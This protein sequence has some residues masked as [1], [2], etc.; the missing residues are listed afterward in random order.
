MRCSRNAERPGHHAG[1]IAW[2]AAV[3]LLMPLARAPG[4][5]TEHDGSGFRVRH[6]STHLVDG[7][8]LLDADISFDF[9][10]AALDAMDHGVPITVLIDMQVR[11]QRRAW[12]DE[13][14]ADV[15]ARYR[16]ETHALTDR[17]VVQNLNTGETHTYR[18]FDE[19]VSALGHITDFPMLDGH[20]LA[21]G[22]E[23]QVRVR[24]RLDIESLPSPL[25]PLAYLSSRW[26][27]DS[28]WYTWEL[29]P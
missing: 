1:P 5:S 8:Y 15:E 11:R 20:L 29:T 18:D 3:F 12:F 2:V 16:I 13:R 9:S 17:Y 27:Q 23:Y 6:A 10:A 7:V 26:R 19:M 22:T 28:D 14:V 24:A 25:R 21:H 4:A